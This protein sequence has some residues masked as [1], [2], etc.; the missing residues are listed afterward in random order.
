[1]I[2]L[3]ATTRYAGWAAIAMAKP[4]LIEIC[5]ESLDQALAAEGGGAD[6]VELCH[7]LSCGGVTPSADLMQ[8]VR[9]RLRIP[10]HGLIR[11]RPGNFYYSG[12][13]FGTLRQEIAVAKDIGL[14]GIVLGALDSS[15]RVD[16]ERTSALVQWSQPLPVTFHR[17]FDQCPDL[18]AALEAVIASGAKRILTSG[19]KLTAMDGLAR[20][21]QLVTLAGDRVA[22]MPGGGVRSDN[23][24]RILRSTGAREIHSSLGASDTKSRSARDMIFFAEEIRQFKSAL[25]ARPPDALQ[26]L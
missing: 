10:I 5:V 18:I 16:Q 7:D 20:L 26:A 22:I 9:R 17:A 3:G 25:E 4:V 6:R 15:G 19:G 21:A 2:T 14:D 24:G 1:V 8:A 12:Q 23:V 13:E 11:P